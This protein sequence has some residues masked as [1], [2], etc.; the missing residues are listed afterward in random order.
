[1]CI[2]YL[3]I[4]FLSQKTIHSVVLSAK[5]ATSIPLNGLCHNHSSLIILFSLSRMEICQ[6]TSM[7]P[8]SPKNDPRERRNNKAER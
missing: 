1:M 8:T 2:N 4:V 5:K 3:H 6:F 7:Y